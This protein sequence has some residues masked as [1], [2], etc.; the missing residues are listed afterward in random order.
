M[1]RE[2]ATRAGRPPRPVLRRDIYV[3]ESD[4]EARAVVGAIL[5]EGY[6][7]TGF[8]QLLVGSADT[9]VERLRR[10]RAMGFDYVMVRHI[11]GDHRL[12]LRSFERIGRDVMPAIKN[13]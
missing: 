3:G 10:Y 4:E 5:A 2:A 13:L 12:M 7:G 11:V 8:D 1:Y 6:R 9:V